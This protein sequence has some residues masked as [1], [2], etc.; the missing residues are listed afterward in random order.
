MTIPNIWVNKKCSKPPTRYLFNW[1]PLILSTPFN[2]MRLRQL[3]QLPLHL[4]AAAPV[5]RHPRRFGSPDARRRG[6]RRPLHPQ[7]RRRPGRRSSQTSPGVPGIPMRPDMTRHGRV[8]EGP[9]M[10]S[11][12]FK[13]GLK[14]IKKG[15]LHIN[16][17]HLVVRKCDMTRY[18]TGTLDRFQP[19]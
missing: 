10:S 1:T 4:D 7:E 6:R 14:M 8:S 9:P 18:L 13:C 2:T 16:A 19:D 15:K 11:L 17:Y 5:A 12:N 3:R